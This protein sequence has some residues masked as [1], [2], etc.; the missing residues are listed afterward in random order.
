MAFPPLNRY[1]NGN[2]RSH[3]GTRTGDLHHIVPIVKQPQ[4]SDHIP[5]SNA[6]GVLL[7]TIPVEIIIQ[8]ALRLFRADPDAVVPDADADSV[9]FPVNGKPYLFF[10]STS[11]R[12]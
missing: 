9:I 12:P 1:K 8:N 3:A 7:Q 2:F 10:H 11:L 6:G 4:P 5:E